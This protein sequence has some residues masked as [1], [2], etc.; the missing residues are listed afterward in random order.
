MHRRRWKGTGQRTRT[1]VGKETGV[2]QMSRRRSK[3]CPS[4]SHS[5]FSA[6][7]LA[8]APDEDVDL[9]PRRPPTAT[10]SRSSPPLSSPP[11]LRPLYVEG[12]EEEEDEED[13]APNPTADH[14]PDFGWYEHTGAPHESSLPDAKLAQQYFEPAKYATLKSCGMVKES[15][16]PVSKDRTLRLALRQFYEQPF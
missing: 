16:T 1:L 13:P 2:V 15:R 4:S 5:Q 10:L 11:S 12:D 8:R 9:A 7:P 14:Q 3:H 6:P